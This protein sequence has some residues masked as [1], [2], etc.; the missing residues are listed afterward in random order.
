M[1][2]GERVDVHYMRVHTLLSASLLFLFFLSYQTI[3]SPAPPLKPSY[4]ALEAL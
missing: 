2:I 1:R 3:L 4:T